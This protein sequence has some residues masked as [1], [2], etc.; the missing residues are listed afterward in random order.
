MQLFY[1]TPF[2]LSVLNVAIMLT[3][4]NIFL[5]RIPNKLPATQQLLIFL[6]GVDV[7]FI[8]FF[9]IFSSLNLS[10]A[11]IA[12]WSLHSVVFFILFLIQFAYHYPR[13]YFK[14]ESKNVFIGFLLISTAVY[15]YYIYHT[16]Q[17]D[18]IFDPSASMFIYLGTHEIGILVGLEL[19]WIMAIFTRQIK[20][21]QQPKNS[22]APQNESQ[23]AAIRKI[24]LL[25]FSPIIFLI[26]I[27]FAYLELA[28]WEIISHL[29]GT[30]MM[31]FVL[32]FIV[33][34]LNNALEPS[35]LQIKMISISLG[36]IL[37]VLGFSTAITMNLHKE[38]F[39]SLKQVEI[40]GSRSDIS[41]G[42]FSN[43]PKEISY[44]VLA[45]KILYRGADFTNMLSGETK[46]W[47]G[48]WLFR[49]ITPLDP[50][51]YFIAHNL[52]IANKEYEI[53]YRYQLFRAHSHK[54]AKQLLYIMFGAVFFIVIAF[55][56]FFSRSLFKPLR[57]LLGGVDSMEKGILNV[58]LPVGVRDEI[59]VLTQS[60]NS[61]VGSVRESREQL[62]AAYEKQIDLTDAYSR[63]VPKEILTTLNKKNI[64]E[65]KLGDN[66]QQEMTVM[67]SDI[68]SFTTISESMSPE[69][70][71]RFINNYLEQVGPFVRKHNGYIDKY[72]G[73]AVMALFP[74]GPD[75]ALAA[76][77]DMHDQVRE[78]NKKGIE[79]NLD[80]VEI[81]IG[82]GIHTGELML[83]TIGEHQR[84]EGTV[85]SDAVNLASR[86]EGLTKAYNAPILIS[87]NSYSKLAQP[88]NFT[89]RRLDRVKVKGKSEWV[90][91][92][93]V[94]DGEEEKQRTLKLSSRNEFN[95]A[96]NLF[97]KRR[98][99]EALEK[100]NIIKEQNSLD[101]CASIYI[102]RCQQFIEQGIPEN[103]DGSFTYKDK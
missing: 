51:T 9:Y 21:L 38:S 40:E 93:E 60:F 69:Q 36:A 78:L 52:T 18:P 34:Y 81:R 100:F 11:T 65:L 39:L 66:V 27:V 7:V 54:M 62:H 22:N 32:L 17:I 48:T 50:S 90:D 95:E 102:E 59:G 16:T 77:I 15:A 55:P 20:K 6:I 35:S 96:V 23:A 58:D 26:L 42:Q 49:K 25:L 101:V 97:Q 99:S 13:L 47:E 12:W 3:L 85:I 33:I 103:W 41:A 37:V 30:G 2:S 71:F 43:L 89:I 79:N 19:F 24:V 74:G 91:I 57:K 83:G 87:N 8:A 61:M 44:V 82:I 88:D 56:M 14:Q 70:I 31:I 28:S 68:R 4:M 86:I 64:L 29:L 5:W 53:G 73:D 46:D 92:I 1:L 84:M 80:H 63:F 98:F 45:N 94:L 67:F 72:I 75:D 10:L 76:A